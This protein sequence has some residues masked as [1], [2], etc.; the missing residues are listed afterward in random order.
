MQFIDKA[1]KF[2]A[3]STGGAV[4]RRWYNPLKQNLGRDSSPSTHFSAENIVSLAFNKLS[5]TKMILGR[6]TKCKHRISHFLRHQWLQSIHFFPAMTKSAMMQDI[7]NTCLLRHC[8]EKIANRLATV[9]IAKRFV[10]CN[11]LPKGRFG[12]FE[13]GYASGLRCDGTL[14]VIPCFETQYRV[15]WM[16]SPRYLSNQ[17]SI[18]KRFL[19]SVNSTN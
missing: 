9:K 11:V 4:E 1:C 12:K 16:F 6:S 7:L 18:W 17:Q 2:L 8:Q 10:L 14:H 19:G 3:K 5:V 15:C 13:K